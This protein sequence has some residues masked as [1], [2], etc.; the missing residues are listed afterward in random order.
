MD[1][2]NAMPKMGTAGALVAAAILSVLVF[3]FVGGMFSVMPSPSLGVFVFAGVVAAIAFVPAAVA[4]RR[5]A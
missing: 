1:P 3:L 2:E 4:L 5:G